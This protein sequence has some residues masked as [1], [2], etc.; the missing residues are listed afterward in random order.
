M[1][2]P[3]PID[4]WA[5]ALLAQFPTIG[6]LI[7]LAFG[8]QAAPP[9]TQSGWSSVAQSIAATTFAL[10]LG[11]IW[12]GASLAIRGAAI[13]RF[14]FRRGGSAEA[15]SL[16]SLGL[17]VLILTTIC[18][19]QCAVL[20]A[21]VRSGCKLHGPW[22]AMFG[23]LVL[24]SAVGLS[25]GLFVSRAVPRVTWATSV[26]V[27]AVLLMIAGGGCI[28]PLPGMNS[29][30]EIATAVVPSRWAFEGLLL[31]EA[32]APTTSQSSAPSTPSVPADIAEPY[33]PAKTERMGPEADA[34]ALA[35]MLIG[36]ASLAAIISPKSK[37]D[38]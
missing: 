22:L 11:A 6:V 9:A 33:F 29:A 15:I 24:A 27:F 25:L 7:V 1:A 37:P 13:N 35:T 12:M 2:K 14:C 32:E 3:G 10:S 17:N 18:I 20:L 19:A 16:V 8:R 4:R 26:L 34:L 38:P 21:I 30:A 31:L 36:L 5:I 23:V 28:W